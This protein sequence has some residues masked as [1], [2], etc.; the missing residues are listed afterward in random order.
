M[1]KEILQMLR[2]R[3]GFI[4]G[5]ELCEV[6]N[7]SRT[8]VWKAIR[9]LMEDGYHIEAIR[10]KGYRLLPGDEVY[11]QEEIE[12]QC[13]SKIMG[14]E[15][16]FKQCVDSTNRL[17][18][19]LASQNAPEG[20]LV[21]SDC[22]TVGKG[23]RGRAWE[24]PIGENIYMTLILRPDIMPDKAS[25]LTLLMAYSVVEGLGYEETQIKWPNDVV[26]DG[27][28]IC[29]ILTEMSADMDGI[30]YIT[31]GVGINVN[32]KIFAEELRNKATS[33]CL[34]EGIP[35]DRGIVIA[36]I[37]ASFEKNY[38]RFLTAR[39]LQSVMEEY[40]R[41]LVHFHTEVFV[42]E[43]QRSYPAFSHGIN[44]FGELLITTKDGDEQAIIAGEVSVRGLYGYV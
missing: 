9:Q 37:M 19:E 4:S 20:T 12:H 27:K 38:K 22:Q 42:V 8:A 43:P 23:R 17:A 14:R 41:R 44:E 16:V 39:N 10:N 26:I 21:V 35:V 29:G 28:K 31:I 34:F 15:V 1:K 30:H 7:V 33:L 40:N 36:K 32:Q 13:T 6:F 18:K 5:Q 24:S 2:N 25:M 11:N 3:E